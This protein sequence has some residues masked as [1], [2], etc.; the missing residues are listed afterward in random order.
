ML[1]GRSAK[2]AEYYLQSYNALDAYKKA[3]YAP[4]S[5]K[6]NAWTLLKRPAIMEAIKAAEAERRQ[7]YGDILSRNIEELT[8]IAYSNSDDVFD[9]KNGQI[10]VKDGYDPR[11]VESV[12][13]GK[14]GLRIK[15]HSKLAA[16]E[17]LNKLMGGYTERVDLTTGGETIT[18]PT[19]IIYE[20]QPQPEKK[21]GA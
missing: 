15:L 8:R 11:L 2:F 7:Q 6:H 9:V 5:A 19:K 21:D 4:G 13:E 18:G 16:I 20:I 3:G 10:N 1:T 17:Q 12:Q 14:A